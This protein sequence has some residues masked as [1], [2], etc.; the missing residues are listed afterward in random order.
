MIIMKKL[1]K[2]ISES[3]CGMQVTNV[4]KV[5]GVDIKRFMKIEMI[6]KELEAMKLEQM[7]FHLSFLKLI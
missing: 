6:G 7:N 3:H 4:H 2:C 5:S 1:P